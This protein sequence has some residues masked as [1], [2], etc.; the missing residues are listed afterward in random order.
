MPVLSRVILIRWIHSFSLSDTNSGG[1]PES[2]SHRR[3]KLSLLRYYVFLLLVRNTRTTNTSNTIN[4]VSECNT[5]NPVR[6]FFASHSKRKELKIIQKTVTSHALVRILHRWTNET[7]VGFASSEV[8]RK[9]QL[10]QEIIIIVSSVESQL[11][12]AI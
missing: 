11:A 5:C 6:V 12:Q 8:K 1:W 9:H 4:R 7:F 3:R 10:R 2:V